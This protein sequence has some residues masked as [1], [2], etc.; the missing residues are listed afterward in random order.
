MA[1]VS[2]LYGQLRPVI[3]VCTGSSRLPLLEQSLP[4]AM[5]NSHALHQLCQA[6]IQSNLA[7]TINTSPALQLACMVDSSTHLAVVG[8]WS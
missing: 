3:S 5:P 2:L 6:L 4:V 8:F 1:I 7:K